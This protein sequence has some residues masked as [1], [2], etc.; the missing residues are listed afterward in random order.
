MV[1][2]INH[3][4]YFKHLIFSYSTFVLE[5]R[6]I[7]PPFVFQPLFQP[8]NIQN[9]NI[10]NRNPQNLWILK[11]YCILREEYWQAWDSFDYLHFVREESKHCST[12]VPGVNSWFREVY[13][14]KGHDL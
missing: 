2:K 3:M 14:S 4:E 1:K 8:R 12:G 7:F 6:G 5:L 11:V 10:Q 9:R 13:P